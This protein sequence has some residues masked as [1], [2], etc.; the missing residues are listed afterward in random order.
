L[1]ISFVLHSFGVIKFI[2]NTKTLKKMLKHC[3][4][5]SYAKKSIFL[6]AFMM[7]A[8]S[9]FSRK[10]YVSQSGSDSY[11]VTQAQNPATPWKTLSKVSSNIAN[12]D[13]ALF[14]KGSR[15]S[16][17]ITI[18]SKSNI[19]FGVY[20]SGADPLFWG[21]GSTIG[22][23]VT[24]R[25]S[26]N[27]T[28]YGW[29]IS[30][31]TIS[32]TDRT[33]QAKIQTVFQL[34]NSSSNN[35]FRKCTMD[36]IGYGA[37]FNV[38]CNTNT[39]D[40]CNIGNLRM[41]R[42][43]PTSVNPDD[44]Y[45]GVPVQFSSRN[46]IFTNNYLHDCYSVS[47]DYGYDGGGVEFF[48]E[49][50]T[51]K[52]NIVKYNTFYD[53]NGAFEF[54]SSPN[55]IAGNPQVDNVIAY[56]KII[57]SSSLW[58]INNNGQY[59]T[60]V[61]NLQFYN[62]VIIQ[63]ATSRTGE[64]KLG[65]MATSDA[66]AGIVVMKNNIFQVSNGASIVRSGQ[67]TAGQLTHTN[68][69]F[70]L[71]GGS[72]TNFT[73]D[74]TEIATSGTIWVNTSNANPLNWDFN[75]TAS[76]PASNAGVYVGITRDFNN[77]IVSNPPDIGILEFAGATPPAA[78]TVTG[79]SPTSGN[80]GQV[81]TLTGTNFLNATSVVLVTGVTV[82]V[83]F[84]VVSATTITVTMNLSPAQY[85]NAGSG[86]IFV[87]TT[88]SGINT[89]GSPTFAYNPPITPSCTFV[90]GA[91]GTCN[92]GVETR[93]FLTSPSGCAGVPDRDSISR[94][95]T[96]P[97]VSSLVFSP[98]NI[99]LVLSVNVPGTLSIINSL[100][101]IVLTSNY[102]SGL[103]FFDVS[104]LTPGNYTA[105]TYG[106]SVGFSTSVRLSLVSTIRPTCR[107]STNGQI[108]VV[109]SLGTAP[110]TYS[111]NSRTVYGSA[112]TFSNLGRG[113]YNIRCKDANNVVTRLTVTLTKLSSNCN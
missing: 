37:Y 100:G 77:Q 104:T 83:P 82:A 112:T 45:G 46:N 99:N 113:T 107:T 88:P 1:V 15:F 43:T 22:V 110:Y 4:S 39:M 9:G 13:S 66:T 23:L 12:G 72:I 17:T 94:P 29:N 55:G 71:S 31:T 74:A 27:I 20:G 41:I 84:T 63:T 89:L 16:G 98:T 44:D 93:T 108:V 111:I 65:S 32:F 70:K 101:Q 86:G 50:D 49:G 40:S 34:E 21:T 24:L 95:C 6:V 25:A 102:P 26:S 69:I 48:E 35:V 33:A 56:N 11:T 73:L 28:F 68:N 105:T 57:N 106:T 91:W 61:T 19:Y 79:I 30:D 75:I 76:S 90:Y 5:G 109:A 3:L 47:Y 62:N 10:F 59:K 67:W 80:Y 36:R 81:V 8:L 14:A 64:T 60:K 18:Q 38:G 53:C 92:S 78:P 97:V 87:V 42:N 51:I 96:A 7:I 58:Y 52:G 85:I 54:G 103:N 2:S